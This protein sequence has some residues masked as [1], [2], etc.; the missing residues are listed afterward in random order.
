MALE[1]DRQLRRYGEEVCTKSDLI[2][3]EEQGAACEHEALARKIFGLVLALATE[4]LK[5]AQAR[6]M[7]MQL[8][9]HRDLPEA[10]A[11]WAMR[12]LEARVRAMALEYAHDAEILVQILS[13]QSGTIDG[14]LQTIEDLYQ[15]EQIS[16]RVYVRARLLLR[17]AGQQETA[18]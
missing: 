3:S 9:E 15:H 17:A 1:E 8:Q 18:N 10:F 2:A 13:L 7:L 5:L 14:L 12:Q 16:Q 6:Q 11:R 4:P